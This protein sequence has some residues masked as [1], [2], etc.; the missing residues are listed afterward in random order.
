MLSNIVSTHVPQPIWD[1]EI[2]SMPESAA[3]WLLPGFIARHNMTLFTSMWKA[4][5]TTLLSRLLTCRTSGQPLLG[6]KVMP[7]KSVVISEEPATMWAERCRRFPFGGQVCLYSQP[8]PGLPSNEE[9]RGLIE[10]VGK[11]HADHGVDLLVIDSVTHF[12]RAETHAQGILEFMMPVRELTSRGMAAVFVHHPRRHG[13]SLGN[14]G[15]GHGAL[16]TEADISI[17]MRHAG[18]DLDSRARRFYCLSRHQDTPRRLL[19]ELNG[20][21]ADYTLLNE[22]NDEGFGEN[23][24][25]LLMVLE[26]APQ[27]LTRF[28]I[29]DEWPADFAK[30]N[31]ATLWRWLEHAVASQLV[32]VEGTGRKADPFRYWIDAAE[33]RWRES[34]IY[35]IFER[36]RREMNLPYRS[37]RECK[38][39]EAESA[40]IDY[41]APLPKGTRLWPPG[42]LMD[43]EDTP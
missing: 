25:T 36:H 4:G 29:L 32:H 19:F 22:T 41:D 12:L 1:N 30:P 28:D 13:A 16:H 31:P 5:K 2:A 6:R 33:A 9:W 20:D 15:R 42:S 18:N 24:Q 21:G 8:F 11:L 43:D 26:D 14:A 34:P 39:Q 27:K 40:K 35:E 37:L 7:G 38:R 17:E 3:S 23:W 10:Q